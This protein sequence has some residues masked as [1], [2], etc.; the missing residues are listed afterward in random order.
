MVLDEKIGKKIT[1]WDIRKNN[2]FFLDTI[3]KR[4]LMQPLTTLYKYI[5]TLFR[6]DLQ[7]V[8]IYI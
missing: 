5:A 2:F 8:I 1:V 4:N 3:K 7:L 6:K